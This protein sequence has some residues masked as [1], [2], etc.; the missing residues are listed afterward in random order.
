MNPTDKLI[1]SLS[2]VPMYSFTM[3]AYDSHHKIIS[4]PI[5]SSIPF[6]KY[7]QEN[8]RNILPMVLLTSVST[9]K[10][11]EFTNPK[12]IYGEMAYHNGELELRLMY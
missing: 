12:R 3:E 2:L 8:D 7:E 4:I 10:E 9:G 6:I 11:L 1:D 5:G